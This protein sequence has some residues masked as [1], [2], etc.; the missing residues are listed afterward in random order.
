MRQIQS[1]N[2]V[3]YQFQL[4]VLQKL[5]LKVQWYIQVMDKECHQKY[6]VYSFACGRECTNQII[7]HVIWCW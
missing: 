4:P 1:A 6:L 5:L 2:D 3:G 7:T